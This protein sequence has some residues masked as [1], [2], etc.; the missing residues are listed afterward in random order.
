LGSRLEGINKE[1]GTHI[2]ISEGTY[3]AAK[4]EI[5]ARALDTVAVKGKNHGIKIYEL[6]G[7]K[8]AGVDWDF[9]QKFE[10][11]RQL[12]ETGNFPDSLR[13]FK[14]LSKT[15]PNDN[16]TRI[17]IDRL[18]ILSKQKPLKWD[19]VYHAIEK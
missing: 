16:P 18:R 6:I 9:L 17:Y 15:N 13:K 10:E 4:S 19:G 14:V 3:N 1:Y 7:L 12:Y 5:V 2:V 11:A 8:S